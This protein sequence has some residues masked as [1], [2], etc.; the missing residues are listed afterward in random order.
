MVK[1]EFSA[2]EIRKLLQELFPLRRL[3]L[4]QFT[5]FNQIGVAKPTGETFRRKRRCYKIADVLPIAVVLALKEQGIP[6]KNIAHVP[7]LIQE[8]AQEIFQF[9]K[10]C[11]LYGMGDSI[12]LKLPEESG[13]SS[14]SS[15]QID[16]L[17]VLLG[18]GS[19]PLDPTVTAGHGAEI[20]ETG[21]ATMG[22]FWGFDVGE[23]AEN[24][25]RAAST[26]FQSD[27]QRAA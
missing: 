21:S 4:S 11:R 18:T 10:G 27:L 13:L 26:V 20:A 16:P 3:V 8:K 23:L 24:L 17:D 1:N 7:L 5:F 22:I 12:S 25:C 9:G 14:G 15:L 2:S 19:S 6:L